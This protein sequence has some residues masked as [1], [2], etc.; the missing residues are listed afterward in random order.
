M[1]RPKRNIKFDKYLISYVQQYM[2][3]NATIEEYEKRYY[4]PELADFIEFQSG[5]ANSLMEILAKELHI[6]G[7]PD[8]KQVE[9]DYEYYNHRI[10][11]FGQCGVKPE[12]RKNEE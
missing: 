8:L 12:Y 4:Y 2:N 7:K 3:I 6:K 1:A 11:T 9:E 10:S 5:V